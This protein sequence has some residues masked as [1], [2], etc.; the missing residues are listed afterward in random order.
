M[1]MIVMGRE[2]AQSAPSSCTLAFCLSDL[3]PL[4]IAHQILS[5]KSQ[6]CTGKCNHQTVRFK[7]SLQLFPPHMDIQYVYVFFFHHSLWLIWVFLFLF[8]V[9][10]GV[11]NKQSCSEQV[12]HSSSSLFYPFCIVLYLSLIHI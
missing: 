12:D 6:H 1:H 4:V 9:L 11:V 10:Q 5:R 8:R 2:T 3:L 7:K